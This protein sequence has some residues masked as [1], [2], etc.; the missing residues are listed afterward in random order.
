MRLYLIRCFEIVFP[1]CMELPL[2][3][4][5]QSYSTLQMDMLYFK[6]V[7]AKENH[8]RLYNSQ[9]APSIQH[10]ITLLYVHT[11]S[12]PQV[13]NLFLAL[14][15]S[16]FSG[17]STGEDEGENNLQIA[18]GRITRAVDWAKAFIVGTALRRLGRKPKESEEGEDQGDDEDPK[19][20]TIEMNHLDTGQSFEMA[21]GIA[22]CLVEGRPSGFI[23]D[24][25]VSLNV[26]IAQGESDFENLDEDDDE[27]DDESEW[28]DEDNQHHH[29]VG[30]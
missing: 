1:L 14:L 4:I 24:G 22:N 26:P 20:D 6:T 17:L 23:V 18:I 12:F 3:Y 7:T 16:S 9:I 21:D 25:E 27:D 10:Y 29:K 30:Q 2:S 11:A 19:K 15:L 28:S 8:S 13:L 5:L